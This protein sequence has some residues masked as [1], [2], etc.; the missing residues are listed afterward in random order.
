MSGRISEPPIEI[1][2]ASRT[3]E[4]GSEPGDS[5]LMSLISAGSTFQTLQQA[6]RYSVW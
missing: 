3:V 4:S 5:G 1:A 6:R 2:M